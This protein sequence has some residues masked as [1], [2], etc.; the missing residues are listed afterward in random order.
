MKR[1]RLGVWIA[2]RE[3]MDRFTGCLARHYRQFE[4]H[5]YSGME[6][7]RA[8]AANLDAVLLEGVRAEEMGA[9][10]PVPVVCLRDAEQEIQSA[11]EEGGM[12]LTEKY[13]DVNGI[14]DEISRR[15]PGRLQCTP[16]RKMSTS[17]RWP[18][19]LLPFSENRSVYFFWTCRRTADFH[20]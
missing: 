11:A 3:F 18:L 7:V 20:S 16:S 15:E 2:D 4:L 9:G 13:Q 8:S 17:F 10:L 5:I 12:Y 1:I 19:R 14:V 6:H